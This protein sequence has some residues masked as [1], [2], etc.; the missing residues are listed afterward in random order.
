MDAQANAKR[1]WRIFALDMTSMKAAPEPETTRAMRRRIARELQ[2]RGF[3]V[4]GEDELLPIWGGM[5]SSRA[6]AAALEEFATA[7]NA[8]VHGWHDRGA[9]LKAN[10]AESVSA[11]PVELAA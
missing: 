6:R 4:L 10:P 3:F 7:I 5:T 8:T 2:R 1:R 11:L 9:M